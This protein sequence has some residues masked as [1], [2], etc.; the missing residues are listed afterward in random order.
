MI[1]KRR[2]LRRVLAVGLLVLL[3]VEW[4]SHSVSYE[5]S[6]STDAPSITAHGGHGDICNTL[7]LCSSS[8]RHDQQNQSLGRDPSQHAAPID[9]FAAVSSNFLFR[10]R[11]QTD[12][13]SGE[14]I[15]R[16]PNTPFH[17]PEIS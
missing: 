17:P 8:S 13:A 6:S 12:F 5:H 9:L 2:N 11:S 10:L 14:A 15:F 4:G 16:P 7:I 1:A 3:L